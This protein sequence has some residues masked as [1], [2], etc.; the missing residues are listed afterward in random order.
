M[1]TK[2][3]PIAVCVSGTG[4]LLDHLIQYSSNNFSKFYVRAVITSNKDTPANMVAFK[5]KLSLKAFNFPRAKII[6]DAGFDNKLIADLKDYLITCQPKLIALCGFLR[7]FPSEFFKDYIIINIHPSLLPKFSG[8]GCYGNKVHTQVMQ[9][10]EKITG[11]SCHYVTD[12]YDKGAIIAQITVSTA[13]C[14]TH[15]QLAN[16]VFKKEKSLLVHSIEYAIAQNLNN[17]K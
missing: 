8:L 12:Q 9:K 2:K 5:N 10:K 17:H 11:A 3:I 1:N 7:P 15:K 4:R 14:K 16:K 13:N 6:K